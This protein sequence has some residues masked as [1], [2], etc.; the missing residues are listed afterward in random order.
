MVHQNDG[1]LWILYFNV[2]L[3]APAAMGLVLVGH[4]RTT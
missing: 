1:D 3:E 2:P 4:S